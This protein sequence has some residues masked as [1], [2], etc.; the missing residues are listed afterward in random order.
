MLC[1]QGRG[2]ALEEFKACSMVPTE[3]ADGDS[4][5][6]RTS[7]GVEHTIRLYGVDCLEAT[8]TDDNDAR[9]L[10]EQ[11]R[12]F[13][14]SE[15]GGS[16]EKSIELAQEYGKR[17]AVETAKALAEPFTIYTSFADGRGDPRFPRFYAFVT[18][19]DGKDLGELLVSKGLARAHGLSRETPDGQHR[20][21]Y[22]EKLRDLELIACRMQS[23]IWVA[24]DCDKLPKERELERKE[25]AELAIGRGPKKI[26]PGT[27]FDLNTA[28][29][30]E[31]MCIP[32]VG[33]KTANLII[34]DRPYANIQQLDNVKGV[35]PKTLENLKK[36]VRIG[37]P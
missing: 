33:E 12:Y 8:V 34:Q 28:A 23:G 7:Q 15:A 21:T 5:L 24:T 17:A 3:W 13:G 1:A 9:R 14:I 10:R 25:E 27:V 11:R 22:A 36:F 26:L 31:L 37:N 20:D 4:F 18:T 35:G 32:G 19:A 16:P 30:D 29:R 2:K 6:I